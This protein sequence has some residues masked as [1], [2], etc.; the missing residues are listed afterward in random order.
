MDPIYP[1]GAGADP[2][3]GPGVAPADE[4]GAGAA[5]TLDVDGELFALSPDD[6]G[7]TAYT[8]LT[9]PNEGYGFGS[10]PTSGWTTEE[11]RDNIRSFLAQ[12][13]PSTGYLE[14]NWRMRRP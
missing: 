6:H 8:R 3:A 2:S 10:S 9:G 13:D 11:H 7:G 12:I 14:D 4:P 5:I 1:G